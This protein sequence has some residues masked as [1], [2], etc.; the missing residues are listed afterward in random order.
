MKITELAAAVVAPFLVDK[1][2]TF[3]AALAAIIGAMTPVLVMLTSS[4]PLNA[5][6]IWIMAIGGLIGAA[7]ALKAFLSTTFADSPASK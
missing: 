1:M 5:R 7:T 2:L 3:Q 6:N 4:A